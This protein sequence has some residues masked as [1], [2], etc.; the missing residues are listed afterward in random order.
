M[1][2]IK[3][4][5]EVLTKAF[6]PTG[7]ARHNFT[8]RPDGKLE[9]CLYIDNV[10]YPFVLAEEEG[11]LDMFPEDLISLVITY[12]RLAHPELNIKDI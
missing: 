2:D 9:L 10:F 7:K 5:L 12:M 6:P 3:Y 8:L 11:D 4:I 1:L